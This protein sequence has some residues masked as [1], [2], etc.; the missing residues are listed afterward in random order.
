ME[1]LTRSLVNDVEVLSDHLASTGHPLPS[2]DRHTPIVVLPNG[3]SPDAHAAR[4]R[5]L[6]NALHL[7]Q[8]AAGPSAYLL[9]LQTGYHYASCVRWL[10]HFRIFHLVPL[11][12]SIAY[13]DL[14][15]LA[16]APECQL[17]SVVRMAMTSGL[18]LESPSQ[19]VSH[20][21]T[22]ALLR[23]DADFHDWAVTMSDLSVPAAFAMVEAHERWPD[24]VEG[25]HTAYNIAVD[26]ELPFFQHLAEHPDRKR[27]FA[28]FMRS[29]ARSQ[30]T[31]AE[32]LAEGWDW[33]ALGQACV[34]D[35]GGSTGHTSVALARKFP[36][37]N[38]VV[39]DL[40]EVVAEGPEY[41]SS[42][43]D[44]Q[45]LRPRISYRAHSFFDP[46]P[47]Q[48]ADV[49]MLRM[50][51]HNWSFADCVRILS[52]LVQTL[53]PGARILIVDIV[54]PD[55]G[56]IPAS[57]ERL[58][59][60]QDLIMRQVFN[61]MERHLENWMDIFKRVD[62]RLIVKSIV[63]PHGSLMSLIELGMDL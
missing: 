53:K 29:M 24:S 17:R 42:L 37:L 19:H 10:C 35:V 57:K 51:L 2:F 43:N 26:T 20:S 21:A 41:L 50:I 59:R 47:V 46:Q 7:F 6:D 12:G 30:G 62:E 25:S 23:N 36:D 11:E 1:E 44:T 45:D 61:S 49:Y 14:A 16:K 32:K 48:D 33:T 39:E 34:V 4:E 63:E 13:A 28:G 40:P 9:N 52:R 38:F 31:E 54:L 15:I 3:A 58:L 8:L 60:V 18:F 22:S 5:I 55:P 56:V 27:Q